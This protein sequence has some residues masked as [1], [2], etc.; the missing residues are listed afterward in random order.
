MLIGIA[1]VP[2]PHFNTFQRQSGKL[3]GSGHSV[4]GLPCRPIGGA[5][6]PDNEDAR[7]LI[8]RAVALIN[9]DPGKAADGFGVICLAH[10]W[11]QLAAF[12]AELFPAALVLRVTLPFPMVFDGEAGRVFFN[13]VLNA[14]GKAAPTLI[15]ATKTMKSEVET[16]RNRS[17]VLLP[18]RAFHSG[19]LRP[20][21]ERL[22]RDLLAEGSP[23]ARIQEACREIEVHH[24]FTPKGGDKGFRDDAD[25]IFRSPGRDLHGQLWENPGEGHEARCALNGRFRLG[26]PIAAGF[27]FDCTRPPRLEGRFCN[28]HDVEANFAGKPHLN[29]APNDFVRG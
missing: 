23:A 6:R 26:G 12:E 18:V 7:R 3:A 1:G 25:V 21:I 28:C 27:H 29:I 13:R 17:P 8:A 10:E 24:P 15:R 11:D 4:F 16:R 5:C 14:I 19:A 22:S 20:S 9:A 2:T